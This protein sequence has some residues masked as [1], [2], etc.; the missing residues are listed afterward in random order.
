MANFGRFGRAKARNVGGSSHGSATSWNP[1]LRKPYFLIGGQHS[2]RS[3]VLIA[4]QEPP[5]VRNPATLRASSNA[6]ARNTRFFDRWKALFRE[7][8]VSGQHKA[9]CCESR[10]PRFVLFTL[11][12]RQ[13]RSPQN[14]QQRGHERTRAPQQERAYS[15][16][17]SAT[18]NSVGRIAM[19]S[20]FAVLRLMDNI[21]LVGNSTGSSLGGVPF[22]ILSTK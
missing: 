8:Q 10:I 20:S 9:G 7:S 15:I 13:H 19:P 2:R 16:T 12:S 17:S 22:K 14:G 6:R 21:I 5:F 4:R 1:L 11:V 3:R 18:P